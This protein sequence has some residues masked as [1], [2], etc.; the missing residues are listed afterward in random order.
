MGVVQ[1]R[2]QAGHHVTQLGLT[3]T[4]LVPQHLVTHIHTYRHSRRL[5]QGRTERRALWLVVLS[6]GRP[7]DV[8]VFPS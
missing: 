7:L 1:G 6:A 5:P 3:L 8:N 2:H 4:R